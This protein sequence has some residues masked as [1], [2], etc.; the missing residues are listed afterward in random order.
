M[1]PVFY[2]GQF[3]DNPKKL[4]KWRLAQRGYRL[5]SIDPACQGVLRD[6]W[7]DYLELTREARGK[8]MKEDEPDELLQ[9][10]N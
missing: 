10:G 8:I 3:R 9:K 7:S 2:Q 1:F 6:T 5:S 4:L